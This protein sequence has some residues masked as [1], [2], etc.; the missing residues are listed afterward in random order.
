MTGLTA[1]TFGLKDRG[2]LEQGGYAD[3]V[4]FD[5]EKVIDTATFERPETPADGILQVFV[6]GLRVWHDGA[7]TAARPGK[8]LRGE[9]YLTQ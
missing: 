1:C 4:L 9:K 7:A 2:I 8:G 5:P 6:N 3:L